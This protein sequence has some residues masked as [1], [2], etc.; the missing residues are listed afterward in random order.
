LHLIKISY[1]IKVTFDKGEKTVDKYT[2]SGMRR[3]SIKRIFSVISKAK[4]ITRHKIA[5]KTGLSLMTVGKITDLLLDKRAVIYEKSEDL[6]VG[7]KAE[8]ITLSD[9]LYEISLVIS[10][11]HIMVAIFDFHLNKC[12]EFTIACENKQVQ[13]LLPDLM[14]E[15]MARLF[16]NNMIGQCIGLGA[17][18]DAKDESFANELA[19]SV[20]QQLSLKTCVLAHRTTAAAIGAS[21][22]SDDEK[23]LYFA[24]D[25]TG[26]EGIFIKNAEKLI[27]GKLSQTEKIKGDIVALT[28]F[29]NAD[30]TYIESTHELAD[31]FECNI[32]DL[33]ASEVFISKGI[34][35]MIREEYVS[36]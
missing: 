18:C 4:K 17:A 32:V 30:E 13:I 15:I 24:K 28:N 31:N 3:D 34:A 29:F 26:F 1:I 33:E 22:G 5:E 6:N 19:F 16:E 21:I 12:D 2:L 9:K 35:Y 7:R 25:S 10:H 8:Y 23:I 14:G 27:C 20:S 11:A 36:N